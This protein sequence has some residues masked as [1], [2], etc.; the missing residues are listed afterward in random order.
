M[1]HCS[2]GVEGVIGE[3]GREDFSPDVSPIGT[4]VRVAHRYL[5]VGR[6]CFGTV[7][8]A[9]RRLVWPMVRMMKEAI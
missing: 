6:Q 4:E 1:T 3:I 2:V 8:P 9:G 5:S 7:S